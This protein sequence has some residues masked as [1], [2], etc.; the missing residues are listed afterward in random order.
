MTDEREVRE[1]E[2]DRPPA[3]L[4]RKS[5]SARRVGVRRQRRRRTARRAPRAGPSAPASGRRAGSTGSPC[6]SRNRAVAPLAAIMKSSIRSRARLSR[7]SARSRTALPS[8]TGRASIVWKSSAPRSRRDR[9]SRCAAASC[10][11]ELR[12]QPGHGA[13]RLAASAPRR[14]AT[15]RRC[16]RPAS[17]GSARARGRRPTRRRRP[18]A[19]TTMS[20][21]MAARS[22]SAFERG[23]VGRQP[24]GQHREDL[25]PA[26]R[27]RWCCAARGRRWRSRRWTRASTSAMATRMRVAPAAGRRRDRSAGRGRASRRCRSS[28][29][30]GRAGRAAPSGTAGPRLEPGAPRRA[31]LAK[32]R[33][34]SA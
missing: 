15:R 4:A 18:S 24:L 10:A 33:A 13:E 21:T 16:C 3:A 29:T 7:S 20:T 5:A 1:P 11:A 32:S 19:S 31:P 17:R 12:V 34:A 22:S 9:R 14:R 27:P 6:A 26:C 2:R 25:R 8:K 23:E 28:T 30:A